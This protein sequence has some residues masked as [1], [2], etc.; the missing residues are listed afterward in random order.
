MLASLLLVRPQST[1]CVPQQGAVSHGQVLLAHDMNFEQ[2]NSC[3]AH[4]IS[5]VR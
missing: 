2:D 3:T 5:L 4:N 1:V